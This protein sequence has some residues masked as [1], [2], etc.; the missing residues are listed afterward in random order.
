MRL[1][2][3]VSCHGFGHMMQTSRVLAALAARDADLD[4]VLRTDIAAHDLAR[5]WDGPGARLPGPLDPALAMSAPDR[6]DFAAT[7]AGYR[8]FPAR[9]E[10]SV[11]DSEAAIDRVRPDLIY[12]NIAAPGLVAGRRK[13]VPTVALCS[14]NWADLLRDA[15]PEGTVGEDAIALLDDAYAGADAFLMPAPSMPMRPHA[16]QTAIGPIGSLGRARGAEVRRVLGFAPD[17]PL[18]LVTWGGWTTSV[19][20]KF[21]TALPEEIGWIFDAAPIL[22]AGISHIDLVAS[23]AI[24]IAKPGY[25][26]F[27]E[28]IAN[29]VRLVHVERPGWPETPALNDWARRHGL[30]VEIPKATGPDDA[31]RTIRALMAETPPAPPALTGADEAAEILLDLAGTA[32]ARR[33]ERVQ[34]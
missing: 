28:A 14:L 15:V 20:A 7:A 11:A 13:G 6:I 12:A 10:A 5:F 23:C 17:M 27:V 24:L 21:L 33:P 1:L 32:V 31:A 8:D 29:R 3:D 4:V 19:D 18:G 34:H 2:A 9:F 16:N 25:G 30:A 26:T 22:A